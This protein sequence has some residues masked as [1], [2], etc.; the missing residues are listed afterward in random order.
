MLDRRRRCVGCDRHLDRRSGIDI[1]MARAAPGRRWRRAALRAIG[2]QIQ[3]RLLFRNDDEGA[4]ARGITDLNR[5]YSMT[6][7]AKGDVMFAATGVT[8]GSML[9]GVGASTAAPDPFHR[10]ALE[11]RHGALDLRQSQFHDQDWP[12]TWA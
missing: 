1:Y 6:D 9:K 7:M 11:D 5:K 3:G 10:H 12:P 4:G 2:G 8:S